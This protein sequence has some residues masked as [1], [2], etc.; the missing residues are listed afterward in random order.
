MAAVAA[1]AC[2][3][4][5]GEARRLATS[6]TAAE[7]VAFLRD[8]VPAPARD[9]LA[10][11]LG[12]LEGVAGVRQL[13]SDEALARLRADLGDRAAVLD[14]VEEG[15]LPATLEIA[16]HAGPAGVGRADAIAWRLR[17]MDGIAE[18]D[19]LRNASDERL[20]R[21]GVRGRRLG[22]LALGIA[23]ATALLA[24]VL[25][26]TAQKARRP[27]AQLLMGFGFTAAGVAAP[28]ALAGALS[29]V[30][31]T[32]LGLALI[33]GVTRLAAR[34]DSGAAFW[35]GGSTFGTSAGAWTLWG[36]ALGAL[37]AAFLIGAALGWWGSTPFGREVE[38]LALAD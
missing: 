16:L 12:K 38:D 32:A 4:S 27:D 17:R 21:A 15:F 8:G 36:A 37:L 25:A 14:G 3:R 1:V 31:G 23:A 9:E 26:A 2:W 10:A 33:V 30:V 35:W 13:A 28:A 29:G 22:Q 20:A 5:Q 24:L 19:V 6:D 11:A 7:L 18:V 34:F